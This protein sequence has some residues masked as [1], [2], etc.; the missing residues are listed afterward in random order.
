M[1]S[2]KSLKKQV[3]NFENFK[4]VPI[5]LEDRYLIMNWRNEQ[6]YH[7]RQN[8]SLSKEMQDLYFN[9]VIIKIF[10]ESNPDQILFSMLENENCIG[11]GGLVHINWVDRN[12]EIS[13]IMD[14]KLECTRFNEIWEIYLKLIGEVAFQTLFLHKIHTYAFDLRPHLYQVFLDAGFIEE[15]RLKEHCVFENEYKDVLIH[16]KFRDK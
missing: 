2:Y 16:S 8:V 3:F 10:K 14:T 1:F 11:Y 12:A 6:I 4:L 7:L 5:R 9:N 13:F 15:A